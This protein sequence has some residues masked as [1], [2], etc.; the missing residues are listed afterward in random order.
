MANAE[1]FEVEATLTTLDWRF[2]NHGL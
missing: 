2:W 1:V